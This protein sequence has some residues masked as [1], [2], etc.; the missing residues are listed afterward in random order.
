MYKHVFLHEIPLPV[1]YCTVASDGR[2]EVGTG[3]NATYV[4][5]ESLRFFSSPLEPLY[6]TVDF[7][8]AESQN[9]VC[10]ALLNTY[11]M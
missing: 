4:P 5:L 1:P 8:M 11:G 10:N 6:I 2:P 9:S 3:C 7:A